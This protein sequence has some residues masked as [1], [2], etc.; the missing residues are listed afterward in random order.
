M[1]LNWYEMLF[2]S[3]YCLSARMEPDGEPSLFSAWFLLAGTQSVNFITILFFYV[4]ASGNR[5]QPSAGMLLA[6]AAAIFALNWLYIYRREWTLPEI[7]GRSKR[8]RLA[9]YYIL[10]SASAALGAM[11]VLFVHVASRGG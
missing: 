8:N 11:I 5:I 1:R 10:L 7:G 3:I 9:F 2:R 4:I 6:V